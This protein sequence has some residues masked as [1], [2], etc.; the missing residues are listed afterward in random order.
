[1]P[2]A[3]FRRVTFGGTVVLAGATFSRRPGFTAARV[4]LGGNHYHDWPAGWSVVPGAGEDAVA[5]LT[6]DES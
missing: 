2:D 5:I 1:V 3:R 6:L 4:G